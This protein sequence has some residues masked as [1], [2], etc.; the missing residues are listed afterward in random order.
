M[1]KVLLLGKLGGNLP[2]AGELTRK[3]IELFGG[4]TLDDARSVFEMN[5]R[6]IDIVIMGGGLDLEDR[7]KIVEYIFKTSEVTTVHM[8]DRA[9][10]PEGFLS[11]VDGVLNGLV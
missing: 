9:T 5:D 1:K 11:F 6:K 8:K 7:L 10:G 2:T 4:S 3:N